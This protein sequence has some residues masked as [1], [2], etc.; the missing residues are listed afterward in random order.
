M[1]NKILWLI[2]FLAVAGTQISAYDYQALVQTFAQ[3]KEVG[4]RMWVE[5]M[6]NTTQEEF[7][8]LL[9]ASS[10]SPAKMISEKLEYLR[11]DMITAT[12]QF[13]LRLPEDLQS[14]L[15]G[16]YDAQLIMEYTSAVEKLDTKY[17]ALTIE[18]LRALIVMQF[19]RLCK[20]IE[21]KTRNNSVITSLDSVTCSKRYDDRLLTFLCDLCDLTL[22]RW[23]EH[24]LSR[25]Q[26]EILFEQQY[27][28]VAKTISALCCC[29]ENLR[30]QQDYRIAVKDLI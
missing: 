6:S 1:E 9:A 28:A 25:Q 30:Q 16:D 11:K 2:I 3:D 24:D 23:A 21:K 12:Q 8:A 13:C 17:P 29:L 18:E 22:Q 7:R 14:A 4:T 15:R 27:G 26:L 19:I 10:G 20:L 5:H